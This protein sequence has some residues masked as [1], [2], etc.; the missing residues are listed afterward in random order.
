MKVANLSEILCLN[1]DLFNHEARH[2][3]EEWREVEEARHEEQAAHF[4]GEPVEL[5]DARAIG[6]LETAG[7]S[8]V[9]EDFLLADSFL[10][11]T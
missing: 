10:R 9:F 8:L 1:P 3:D 6:K 5:V 4:V 11:K 2:Q 7:K